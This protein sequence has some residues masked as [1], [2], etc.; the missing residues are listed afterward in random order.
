MW[1]FGYGDCGIL[2][3]GNTSN[4]STPKEIRYFKDKKIKI[5][6]CEGGDSHSAVISDANQLFMFGRGDSGELG[7]QTSKETNSTPIQINAFKDMKVKKVV[8][9]NRSSFVIV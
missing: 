1:S 4:V 2:G 6:F 9:G 8:L 7:P 3:H 5:I